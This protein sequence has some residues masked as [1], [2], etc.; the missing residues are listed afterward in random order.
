MTVPQVFTT[1]GLRVAC[2]IGSWSH[3]ILV[4]AKVGISRF[5]PSQMLVIVFLL[6]GDFSFTMV[7][8]SRTPGI[9]I[10]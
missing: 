8:D 3:W 2:A 6:I 10:G 1:V 7:V 4:I 5:I 9:S